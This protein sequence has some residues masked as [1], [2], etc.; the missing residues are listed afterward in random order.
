[1][2]DEESESATDEK[3]SAGKSKKTVESREDR[4]AAALRANLRRRKVQARGRKVKTDASGST[5]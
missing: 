1:M 3:R 4:V 2:E 5:S